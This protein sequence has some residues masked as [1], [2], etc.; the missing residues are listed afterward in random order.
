MPTKRSHTTDTSKPSHAGIRKPKKMSHHR[1]R[2]PPTIVWTT[3][4]DRQLMEAVE[5]PKYIKRMKNGRETISW[6]RIGQDLFHGTVKTQVIHQRYYRVLHP[7]LKI[8]ESWTEEEDVRILELVARYGPS[9]S[10][11]SKCIPGR[12]DTKIKARYH[13]LER[14]KKPIRSHTQGKKEQTIC[15]EN[16]SPHCLISEENNNTS[17]EAK[18][19]PEVADHHTSCCATKTYS[20]VVTAACAV[21]PKLHTTHNEFL[22]ILLEAELISGPKYCPSPLLLVDEM[23]TT[24]AVGM[25]EEQ[26]EVTAP[27]N[28]TVVSPYCSMVPKPLAHATLQHL[29]NSNWYDTQTL[30][31]QTNTLPYPLHHL[32]QNEHPVY[33]TFTDEQTLSVLCPTLHKEFPFITHFDEFQ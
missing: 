30:V 3:T 32:H 13:V 33:H 15:Y 2:N 14:Q 12:C 19:P 25:E 9:W 23:C 20:E 29:Y 18:E 31:Q 17:L 24:T 27:Q 16:E 26:E 6:I 4:L 8:G 22:E 5:N 21:E 1:V 10:Q 28:Q 11:I 7:T